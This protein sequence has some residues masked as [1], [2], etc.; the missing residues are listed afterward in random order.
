MYWDC[1]ENLNINASGD[2]NSYNF[3]LM[4]NFMLLVPRS[5]EGY[6]CEETGVTVNVNSLGFGGTFAVKN[7]ETLQLLL[8]MTPTKIL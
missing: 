3:L 1:V 2:E 4:K 8:K 7:E 6:R 5:K